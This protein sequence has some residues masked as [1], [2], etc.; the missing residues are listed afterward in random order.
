MV[1]TRPVPKNTNNKRCVLERSVVSYCR[2]IKVLEWVCVLDFRCGDIFGIWE[3]CHPS[4][5]QPHSHRHG[6]WYSQLSFSS[7]ESHVVSPLGRQRTVENWSL[8]TWAGFYF[9]KW[10]D[11]CRGWGQRQFSQRL[12]THPI[13]MCVPVDVPLALCGS[14]QQEAAVNGYGADGVSA[15]LSRSCPR[16]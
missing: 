10:S 16:F 14:T 12:S 13:L 4:M 3:A 9:S 6:G 15:A 5:N 2:D 8:A 1:V 7:V 11:I